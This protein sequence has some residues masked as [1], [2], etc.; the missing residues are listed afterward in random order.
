MTRL[1]KGI[2]KPIKRYGKCPR[3]KCEYDYENWCRSFALDIYI[4]ELSKD[5][6]G[7]LFQPKNK[8]DEHDSKTSYSILFYMLQKN[9]QRMLNCFFEYI[10]KERIQNIEYL[11]RGGFSVI[12][13]AEWLDGEIEN[14]NIIRHIIKRKGPQFI[15]LKV[16]T[17]NSV[18][19]NELSMDPI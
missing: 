3:C 1:L 18:R 19:L 8:R 10:P 5:I 15:A 4:L 2:K 9:I 6:F 13:K 14:R 11:T 17:N 16:I 12:Y 7:Y